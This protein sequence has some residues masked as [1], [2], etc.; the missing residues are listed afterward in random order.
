M[1]LIFPIFLLVASFSSTWT[2]EIS[3]PVIRI[4]QITDTHIGESCNGDLSYD[5]CKPVRALTDAVKKVNELLP[6]PTA[7]FVT[8]DITSSALLV[9]FQKANE[10]LSALTMPWFPV[11]GN[12]DS[13]PYEKK[14]DGTFTQSSTPIGDEY[15]A[16]TFSERL[17]AG[18]K[19]KSGEVTVSDWPTASCKN[20]DF[21]FQTWHHNFIVQ[22]KSLQNLK[23]LGLDWTA[24]GNALPEPG[25]G[26][27]AEL[28]NYPCGT[29]PWLDSHLKT[30]AKEDTANATKFFIAQHHPFHNRD[31]WSPFGK[32]LIK[33]FTF[34]NVQSGMVQDVF[35]TSFP[36]ES[37]LGIVAGH[38]HRWFYG[39]AWTRFTA[40]DSKWMKVKEWETSACKGWV[41][42]ADFIAAFT[43]FDFN[44]DEK[45]VPFMSNVD[46]M[47]KTPK[48]QW[49]GRLEGDLK[50]IEELI[51]QK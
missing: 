16:Q 39:D 31:A 34:D 12:H 14:S 45:G 46:Y 43:I 20:G 38:M 7:V 24:R 3:E 5:A 2:K 23:V 25:V 47:W 21:G 50:D 15:F 48:G 27:E 49:R 17:N 35:S 51:E 33:N 22:F 40:L 29:L 44:P 6:R 10:I 26:P 11:L 18:P 1:K 36:A 8:G 13:W 4:V 37:I 28:H 41:I 19:D 30:F 42:D 9:E 32:N